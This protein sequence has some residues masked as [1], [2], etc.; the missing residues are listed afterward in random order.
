MRIVQISDIHLCADPEQELLGVKTYESFSAVL[1]LLKKDKKTP[2]IVIISGDMSQDHTEQSYKNMI[3]L[4][5]DFKM[6][7][8]F[9]AGNH[10][11][12]AI[13]DKVFP[14]NNI[15]SD[16]NIIFDKWN[17]ILL[18]SQIPGRVHGRLDASQ[19]EFMKQCLKKYPDHKAI[20][21]FHHQPI[22]V[23]CSWLDEYTIAN[24]D[25]FWETLKQYPH[26][27]AI[28]FGHVHQVHEGCKQGVNYYSTPATCIQFMTNHDDFA[29][30][31]LNPGYRWIELSANGE[32]ST[33][34]YRT[35][36]YI[37][38]FQANAKGYK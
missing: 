7:I 27:K 13:M 22:P 17:I 4:L 12:T 29:L 5:K 36:K 24:A 1:D 21:I 20:L 16:K 28:F 38:E 9:V 37:G 30:E 34:V 32:I 3:Y 33:G 11:D 19:I 6:P 2:D 31:K 8:Y 25:E 14:I 10:D 15:L 23:G 26:V 18:N 35:A